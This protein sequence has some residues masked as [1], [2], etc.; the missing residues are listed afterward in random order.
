MATMAEL[1]LAD[2]RRERSTAERAARRRSF[3]ALLLLA[4]IVRG[5]ALWAKFGDLRG[6]PDG[7]LEIANAVQGSKLYGRRYV[8]A[9][10]PIRRWPLSETAYRPPLYPYALVAV[11]GERALSPLRIAVFHWM[12]GVASVLLTYY[13]AQQWRLAH[14]VALLAALLVAVDPILL[15]QST[16]VMTETIATFVALLALVALTRV[17]RRPEPFEAALAGVSLGVCALCRPTFFVWGA[18]VLCV[19]PFI[20]APWLRRAGNLAAATTMMALVIAPWAVRN[21]VDLGTPLLSTTHGGYT[22]ALGNHRDFFE[23]LRSGGWNI[24]YDAQTSNLRLDIA[25]QRPNV[26]FSGHWEIER[27]HAAYLVAARAV[28][29]DPAM[30][31]VSCVYRLWRFWSPLPLALTADESSATTALRALVTGWYLLILS[32]ALS[33]AWRLRGQLVATPWLW[34]TLLCVSFTLTHTF[35]WSDMRMRAPLMPVV[36][37]LA[38]VGAAGLWSRAGFAQCSGAGVTPVME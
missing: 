22:L 37:M 24:P 23:H 29:D 6:D 9:Y 25:S 15:R 34:G 21:W 13:L 17:A 11:A 27:D 1:S 20:A 16:L 10:N 26:A 36:A 7:Y 28:R 5:G 8:Y 14:R 18:V 4:T 33:G 3:L 12:L 38:A 32:L 31:A 19:M 35:Y 30:F 2:A